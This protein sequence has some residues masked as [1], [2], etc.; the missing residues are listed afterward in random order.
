M[1]SLALAWI[2]LTSC[3]LLCPKP[4]E[5]PFVCAV[6]PA[7]DVTGHDDTTTYRVNRECLRGIAARLKAAYKE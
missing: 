7:Y 2:G 4:D 1:T 6:Q 5:E 3:S